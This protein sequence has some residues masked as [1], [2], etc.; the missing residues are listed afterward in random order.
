MQHNHIA[1]EHHEP[2]MQQHRR[3]DGA[4]PATDAAPSASRCGTTSYRRSTMASRCSTVGSRC[5][6]ITLAMQRRETAA[7]P[8][9][10]H[11]GPIESA[12]R[13][14]PCIWSTRGGVPPR[15]PTLTP[16]QSQERAPSWSNMRSSDVFRDRAASRRTRRC[17]SASPS[18]RSRNQKGS[19]HRCRRT[20]CSGSKPCPVAHTRR[21]A[22]WARRKARCPSCRASCS[23]SYERPLALRRCSPQEN[24]PWS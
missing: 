8:H 17:D 4:P 21:R 11:A 22:R 6:S 1:M 3:R 19:R 20:P 14:A 15:S 7:R 12:A 16:I 2:P 18:C 10:R 23:S 24:R 9:A 13:D 5:S